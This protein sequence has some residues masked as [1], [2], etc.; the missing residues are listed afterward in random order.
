MEFKAYAV[1]VTATWEELSNINIT[2]LTKGTRVIVLDWGLHGEFGKPGQYFEV[3]D[4][5]SLQSYLMPAQYLK[6]V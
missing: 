4:C 2:S 3:Y 6:L 1:E 5:I